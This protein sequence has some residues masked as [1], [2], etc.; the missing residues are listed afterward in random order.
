MTQSGFTDEKIPRAAPDRMEWR[1]GV[2]GEGKDHREAVPIH[3]KDV[4]GLNQRPHNGNAAG[5]QELY[6]C[7]Y[8]EIKPRDLTLHPES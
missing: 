1:E 6:F 7:D 3:A 5:N 2:V 4:S 8:P